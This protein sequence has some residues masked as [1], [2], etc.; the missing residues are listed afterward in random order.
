MIYFPS[1]FPFLLFPLFLLCLVLRLRR[2]SFCTTPSMENLPYA[3]TLLCQ[4]RNSTLIH[5]CIAPTQLQSHVISFVQANQITPFTLF[6]LCINGRTSFC[7]RVCLRKSNNMSLLFFCKTTEIELERKLQRETPTGLKQLGYV[8]V[9]SLVMTL[10]QRY[11]N[12]QTKMLK[13]LQ[14]N[15][16]P[17]WKSKSSQRALD[18][19]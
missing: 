16:G 11:K 4:G 13:Q 14:Q 8:S 17:K 9:R 10:P 2:I 5:L 18:C 1:P 19:C 12:P 6:H 7:P 15:S 3:L